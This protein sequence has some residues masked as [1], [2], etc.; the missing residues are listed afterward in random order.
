MTGVRGRVARLG[1]ALVLAAFAAV[2]GVSSPAV[3]SWAVGSAP[4]A[5][6]EAAAASVSAGSTPTASVAS[7]GIT[8][9]WPV[10]TLSNGLPVSGYL[11][12]RYASSSGQAQIVGSG[13]AGTITTTSCTEAAVPAGTW[14]YNVTP[15]Y[16][17][18]WQGQA[19]PMSTAVTVVTSTTPPSGGSVSYMNGYATYPS[20]IVS[21]TPGSDSAGINPA[22][23][24][25]Q[26]DSA[27]LANGVCGTFGAFAAISTSPVSPYTDAAVSTATCYQYRY[28]ISDYAGNQ[29]T[30]TSSNVAKLYTTGLGQLANANWVLSSPSIAAS[31]TVY[32]YSFATATSSALSSVTMTVPSGTAGT[33]TLGPVSG[34]PSSGTLALSGNQLSYSFSSIFVNGGTAVS[35]QVTGLTNTSTIGT[36][37]R[38][39][40]H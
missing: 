8:V 22:T 12:G 14:Q 4:G 23:G 3:A 5:T 37:D 35:I 1:L 10:T 25:L 29:A 39:A 24:I 32:T 21:F 40:R 7:G 26:R 34:V 38:A 33:P 9:S 11:V 16:S 18:Y 2:L 20:V 6:G 30:Y 27:T 28:L 36:Y 15:L 19:S 13:C 31:A 17:T